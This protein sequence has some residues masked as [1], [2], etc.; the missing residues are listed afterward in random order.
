M[1]HLLKTKV[2]S[3]ILLLV[4]M[5]CGGGSGDINTSVTPI[6]PPVA[7]DPEPSTFHCSKDSICPEIIVNGDPHA[8]DAFRGYGDPS[9]EFDPSTNTLWMSYSW[10]NVLIDDVGPPVSFDLGVRTHLAKSI[11]GGK[12]FEFVRAVNQPQMESHPDTGVEGWSTHEVS[13][14]IKQPDGQWQLLWFKYFNPFGT[15]AGVDEGQEFLYWKSNAMSP[16]NLGDDSQVWASTVAASDSWNAPLDLNAVAGLSDCTVMTEP[17]LFSFENEIYLA[18]SCL[19]LDLAG[20]RTDLERLVLLRQTVDGYD[21]IGNILD[22]NDATQLGVDVI[23]QAD[24]SIAR[25]GSIIM[26]VTPIILKGNPDHQGCIVY[27]FEDISRALIKRNNNGEAVARN[28]ITA[29]GN[30]LGPGLCSYDAANDS[31]I[32]MVITTVSQNST[33]IEFSLRATG[34]H[35]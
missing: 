16:E 22:S 14:M 24:I 5:G 13:T 27:E 17:A 10:L 3:I 32:L 21:F 1:Y 11:D 31:G 19:V 23:Q 28:I 18:S 25:D 29:D 33:D 12:T 8:A 6:P 34:V 15:V 9:L 7:D 35:P 26:L 20:R 2:L 4:M 30:G